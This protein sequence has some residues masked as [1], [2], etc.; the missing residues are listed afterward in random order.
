MNDISTLIVSELDD[1][2]TLVDP[3][4]TRRR[5]PRA[6][7]EPAVDRVAPLQV[8][9]SPVGHTST[10]TSEIPRRRAFEPFVSVFVVLGLALV[11][12]QQWEIAHAIRESIEAF[13]AS[14][15]SQTGSD[16]AEQ[17]SPTQPQGV[18]PVAS[19]G[20]KLPPAVVDREL[21]ERQ[22]VSSFA[23]NDFP[24]ALARYQVLSQH[25]PE[26]SPYPDAVAVLRTKLGC[27]LDTG[28]VPGACQ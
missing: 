12:Y 5:A 7:V 9:T 14:N 27:G 11:A 17:A 10:S 24:A 28:T 22:A 13:A 8:Q 25:F 4:F 16:V 23:S 6:S 3:R 1:E 21:M 20:S 15:P 19:E 2:R 18:S 26:F